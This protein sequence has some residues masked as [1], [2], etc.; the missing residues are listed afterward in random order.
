MLFIE[1]E[2]ILPK[3]LAKIHQTARITR[4]KSPKIMESAEICKSKRLR[5]SSSSSIEIIRS[6]RTEMPRP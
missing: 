6:S 5:K 3:N 1:K 4:N 2:N